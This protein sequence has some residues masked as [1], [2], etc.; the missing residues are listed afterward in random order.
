MNTVSNTKRRR[1]ERW[2]GKSQLAPQVCHARTFFVRT[3]THTHTTAVKCPRVLDLTSSM[4]KPPPIFFRVTAQMFAS[5]CRFQRAAFS[6]S[7]LLF[8]YGLG[9]ILSSR[10][11]QLFWRRLGISQMLCVRRYTRARRY[12]RACTYNDPVLAV[13]NCGKE[14]EKASSN[15]EGKKYNSFI[16]SQTS[17][18]FFPSR[19]RVLVFTTFLCRFRARIQSS[20]QSDGKK[21]KH[22]RKEWV[23]LVV[24][25]KHLKWEQLSLAYQF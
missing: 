5:M 11:A 14:R 10:K 2:G 18:V 24:Y 16:E 8:F 15:G 12:P 21:K 23:T 25:A 22:K 13:K 17:R 6:F 20:L 4:F 7:L 9:L 1:G 3:R 19:R